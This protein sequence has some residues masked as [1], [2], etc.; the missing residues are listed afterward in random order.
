[1]YAAVLDANV[2]VPSALCDTLLRLAADGFYRP[3]WSEQILKEVEHAILRIRPELDH[4]RVT[5]RIDAM[6]TAFIDANVEGWEEVA[7]G[8]DLPDP[9]DRHVLAAAIAGGAQAIVTFNV[10]D[11]PADRLAPRGIE[12]RQPDEFLLDQL[13]LSP[14][15]MLEVLISQAADLTHP[16]VDLAGLLN[17]LARCRLPSFV[18]A[19]RRL[20][21]ESR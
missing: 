4:A 10:K 2:L 20:A 3:L 15:G 7:A 17:N 8:L 21:P 19:A 11:F 12:A 14:S 16:P 18:E 9:D 13:D 5:R 1:M 6:R